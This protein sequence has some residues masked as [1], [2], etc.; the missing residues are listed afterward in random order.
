MSLY[1]EDFYATPWIASPTS[2]R[3]YVSFVGTKALV[4]VQLLLQ[5]LTHW[6]VQEMATSQLTKL[7]V[8]PKHAEVGYLGVAS[9]TNA[10]K[11]HFRVLARR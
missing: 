6:A 9:P 4:V 10:G 5:K 1:D 2:I 11:V 3:L 7:G 8:Q